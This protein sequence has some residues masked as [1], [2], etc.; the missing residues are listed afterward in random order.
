MLLA[1]YG[2]LASC[3]QSPWRVVFRQHTFSDNRSLN[4][5]V[6]RSVLRAGVHRHCPGTTAAL[7]LGTLTGHGTS[8]ICEF[9]TSRLQCL[10][11][12]AFI[13]IFCSS[14][15]IPLVLAVLNTSCVCHAAHCAIAHIRPL[16]NSNLGVLKA[17]KV[18][19]ITRNLSNRWSWT[20]C[21]CCNR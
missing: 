17:A 9:C 11:A 2:E 13:F 14:I 19:P 8:R 10:T 21:R 20:R 4:S 16:E 3:A 5:L 7:S 15:Q 1:S 12:P 18:T 6:R